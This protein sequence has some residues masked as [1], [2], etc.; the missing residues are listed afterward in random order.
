MPP[1]FKDV[2]VTIMIK[3]SYS[4]LIN[5]MAKDENKYSERM[6]DTGL[7]FTTWFKGL[8]ESLS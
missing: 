2:D 6:V 4:K 7:V 1:K 5:D 8:I 3:L